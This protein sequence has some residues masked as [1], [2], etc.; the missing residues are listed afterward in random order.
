MKKFQAI[1]AL[2]AV[3]C[4]ASAGWAEGEGEGEHADMDMDAMMAKWAETSSPGEAHKTFEYYVG[5]W[6]YVNVSRMMG[7]ETTS[8]GTASYSLSLGGRYLHNLT[9]GEMNGL[10]FEA[11]AINGYDNVAGEHYNIWTDN[12]GTGTV[13]ARGNMNEDGDLVLTGSMADPMMGGEQDFKY[14][15]S[16]KSDDSFVFEMYLGPKGGE[17]ERVM[18]ITYTRV[19]SS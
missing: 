8:E 5:D 10:P 4:L 16:V 15:S 14:V 7:Q 3:L 6:T 11:F 9:H 12:M 19:K 18:E 1:A 17:M 2:L 13:T